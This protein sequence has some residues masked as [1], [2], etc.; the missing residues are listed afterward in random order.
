[1]QDTVGKLH[2]LD[3]KGARADRL[4]HPPVRRR[5]G[6]HQ[7]PPHQSG[8]AEGDTIASNGE[9]LVKGLDNLLADIERGHGELSIRQSADGF[10]I[11]G[12]VATTP[13]KVVFRNRIM[14]LLQYS[15][16][17]DEVH[18]RPLLI[19]PALDQ[20]VLHHRPAARE[21]LR[22]LAGGPGLYRVPGQLGES[23]RQASPRPGFEDYMQDGIFA[24]L[25]AVGRA[26]GVTRS[27]LR[28]LLHRRHPARLHPRLHGGQ[29]R[30]PDSFRHLLGGAD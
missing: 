7:L 19:F 14:E 20:Q 17:T 29:G 12:N 1:M 6:A 5:A 23:G 15:P 18:E 4:L 24:A 3:E 21:Q 28:R 9:N 26:T 30:R 22:P 25:E 11:G 10:T 13:G 2:G 16:T 8:C 27:Q